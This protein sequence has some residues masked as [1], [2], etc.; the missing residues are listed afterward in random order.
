MY[1]W[2]TADWTKTLMYVELNKRRRERE[3]GRERRG[4]RERQTELG[5]AELECWQRN[6]V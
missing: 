1:F 6:N 2:E 5:H 3:R 4:G